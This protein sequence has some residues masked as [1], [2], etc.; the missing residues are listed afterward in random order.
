[1]SKNYSTIIFISSI[2]DINDVI[3]IKDT[4]TNQTSTGENTASEP[5]DTLS[6][7]NCYQTA[8]DIIKDLLSATEDNDELEDTPSSPK[9]KKCD[10]KENSSSLNPVLRGIL[11]DFDSDSSEIVLTIDENVI[12][13]DNEEDVNGETN[14]KTGE[15]NEEKSNENNDKNVEGTENDKP[16]DSTKAAVDES[17][18]ASTAQ[19]INNN[20]T[21]NNAIS[22][23]SI[24][25]NQEI[26]SKTDTKSDN[27]PIEKEKKSKRKL[28]KKKNLEKP[29]DMENNLISDDKTEHETDNQLVPN[30]SEQP[31]EGPSTL[32]DAPSV[33]ADK[34]NDDLS[35][36]GKPPPK[37][38]KIPKVSITK[39]LKRK[40][41]EVVTADKEET[42]IH[43]LS[44][45]ECEVENTEK[46]NS[47]IKNLTKNCTKVSVTKSLKG[48]NEDGNTADKEDIPANIV[49]DD[50]FEVKNTE[51]KTTSIE[52]N[53]NN[54]VQ[55]AEKNGTEETNMNLSKPPLTSSKVDEVKEK[56]YNVSKVVML[57]SHSESSGSDT[58][59]VPKRT[60]TKKSNRLSRLFGFSSGK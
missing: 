23:D 44:E 7:N 49:A 48:Q 29:I 31:I 9:N 14:S 12:N 19:S 35:D 60:I 39:P 32:K 37:K 18:I 27:L 13:K 28:G 42:S 57:P 34:V 24:P 17:D 5:V 11:H 58:D 15:N 21:T 36:T 46:K 45:N 22:G 56:V 10:T 2:T 51:N 50:E 20:N 40:N 6:S 25:C 3:E 1:M 4:N 16:V 26:L 38:A 30:I 52:N 53:N 59:E 54:K 43:I 8:Q 41:R 47:P 55:D 33:I